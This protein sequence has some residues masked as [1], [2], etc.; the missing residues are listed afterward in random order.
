MIFRLYIVFLCFIWL[1]GKV[2]FPWNLTTI[3]TTK[4]TTSN[5]VEE[6]STIV[7]EKPHEFR[8]NFTRNNDSVFVSTYSNASDSFVSINN[9]FTMTKMNL[10]PCEIRFHES[11]NQ[12][13]STVKTKLIVHFNGRFTR[14][15][16][17]Q[18]GD[19]LLDIADLL[20][21]VRTM[22]NSN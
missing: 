8:I 2:I 7:N 13:N 3:S 11:A 16:A 9:T 22:E 4:K 21:T 10:N 12:E 6:T 14:D 18:L 17:V 20:F 19:R 5:Y 15:L 1:D